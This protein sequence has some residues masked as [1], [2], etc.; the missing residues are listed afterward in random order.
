MIKNFLFALLLL[1]L[2]PLVYVHAQDTMQVEKA[3]ISF[4]AGN[5]DVD[6][7]PDNEMEDFEIAELDMRLPAGT[8]IR[9]GK[10]GLCEITLPDGSTIKIS[11]KTVF[12]IE[13]FSFDS[14]MEKKKGRFNLIFGRVRAKV[15][16][17]VTTDS[18]FQVKA[19]TA[20]AG[21]RGTTFG[22]FFD[23]KTAQIV[24][25]EG[26]INLNSATGAFETL[27]IT[28]GQTGT[29][30]S[31][32]FAGPITEVPDEIVEEWEQELQKFPVEAEEIAAEVT[33]VEK[34]KEVAKKV[35]KA[36]KGVG[37]FGENFTMT[38]TLGSLAVDNVFYNRW[39]LIPEY[40]REKLGVGLYVPAIFA[41]DKG[42]FD[43]DAWENHD[44]WNF[45]D[46]DDAIHDILIKI[47]Y[48]LYF[49]LGNIDNFF[50]GHGFI[51]DNYSN[52]LYFPEEL[53]TGFQFNVD[54]GWI[55]IETIVPRV[56]SLQTFAG[57]LYF[58]PMGK[59]I[60]FAIGATG[61]YDKPKPSRI[62][63]PIGPLGDQTQNSDQ[64]PQILVF[65]LDAELPILNL[66]TFSLKLYADAAKLGY[67]YPELH[68]AL[69]NPQTQP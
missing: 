63:W 62:G 5:V 10:N 25:F 33:K 24:V 55:G 56:S 28:E 14:E 59:R 52:M 39:V 13:E 6:Y 64:L 54:A 4:L 42:L 66:K 44:E 30:S 37:L 18:E 36:K 49:K 27:T 58:R 16:K 20:L 2:F 35:K 68:P 17:L 53:N 19:G 48:V 3:Y 51:V 65:G 69:A 50:L 41:P 57:R 29:V 38:G 7:T 31:D 32:G 34:P 43:F 8:I 1:L 67:R 61:F 40:R 9:T 11:P 15:S 12:Q 60:P 22:V 45:T 46:F 23:G 26:S 21:V 47:Y